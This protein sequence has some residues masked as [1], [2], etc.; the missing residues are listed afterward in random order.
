MVRPQPLE[1]ALDSHAGRA[2]PRAGHGRAA[3]RANRR[4]CGGNDRGACMNWRKLI[5]AAVLLLGACASPV[6]PE[7]AVER[8]LQAKVS[9]DENT[10][11]L[12]LCAE[13][14]AQLDREAHTFDTVTGV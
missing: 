13:M 1:P 10:L 7:D 11:R 12:L 14:E 4:R 5:I 6:P 2:A 8:Y 9:G 3:A